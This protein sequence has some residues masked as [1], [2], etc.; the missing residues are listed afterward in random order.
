MPKSR[1]ALPLDT[2]YYTAIGRV[3]ARAAALDA[4]IDAAIW[5]LTGMSEPVGRIMTTRRDATDRLK[6]LR[7]LCALLVTEHDE[8]RL[9]HIIGE[10]RRTLKKRNQII[11]ALWS[12]GT[13]GVPV[14][15]RYEL[16]KEL[17]HFKD[18]WP[19]EK[20]N[21]VANELDNVAGEIVDFLRILEPVAQTTSPQKSEIP[22]LNRARPLEEDKEDD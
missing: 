3:T 17:K 19:I 16:D 5:T 6:R 22:G 13:D 10:A 12:A 4:A 15:H 21:R 9:P 2:D 7:A 8:V 1:I 18:E 11:H 14:S 20:I